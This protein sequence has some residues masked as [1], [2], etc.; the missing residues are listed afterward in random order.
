MEGI[1]ADED[2]RPQKRRSWIG[3]MAI[4]ALASGTF[5]LGRYVP[6]RAAS[7]KAACLEN[8]RAIHQATLEWTA[9]SQRQTTNTSPTWDE[10]RP[11]LIRYNKSHYA[12]PAGGRYSLGT[13][14][15]PPTC[16]HPGHTL[17]LSPSSR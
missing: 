11:Y 5:L 10:L 3:M 17:L 16:S 15:A 13:Q 7:P 14:D 12:C 8:L 1:R 9:A 4:V 2:E 6:V